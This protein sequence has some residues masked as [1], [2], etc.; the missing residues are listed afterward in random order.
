M[1]RTADLFA[2][3][4][5]ESRFGLAISP[6]SQQGYPRQQNW[7]KGNMRYVSSECSINSG[8]IFSKSNDINDA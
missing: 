1:N 7:K 2:F 6:A 3:Q 5:H 4:A 8:F